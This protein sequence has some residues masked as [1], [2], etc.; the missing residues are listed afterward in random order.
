[1]VY[2]KTNRSKQAVTSESF[3]VLSITIVFVA[4]NN[5]LRG[6]NRKRRQKLEESQK[7]EEKIDKKRISRENQRTGREK[8]HDQVVPQ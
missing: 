5:R 6:R 4:K 3:E 2:S 7:L 8:H 1:V